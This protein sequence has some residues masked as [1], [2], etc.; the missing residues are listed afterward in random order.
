MSTESALIHHWSS[1]LE[2]YYFTIVHQPGKLQGHMDALSQLPTEWPQAENMEA[3]KNN[4]IA[5]E[6]GQLHEA[7]TRGEWPI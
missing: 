1:E 2:E 7:A 5:Q 3:T 4:N 6:H